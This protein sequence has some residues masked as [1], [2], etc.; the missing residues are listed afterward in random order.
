MVALRRVLPRYAC[1]PG[2]SGP[3]YAS[4][5]VRRT[6]TSPW[7][8]TAPSRRG[9]TSRTG[10]ARSSR[11]SAQ[12]VT[13]SGDGGGQLG[14]LLAHPLRGGATP[15]VARRHRALGG[16][17]LAHLRRQVRRDLR[18]L[19][20]AQ[21]V[22]LDPELL[23]PADA[24]PGDLVGHPEGHALAHQPLGDVGDRK[25]TRLNSSHSQISYA[26]FCL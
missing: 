1:E 12:P 16:E 25:S 4:T 26:V 19:L 2:S 3:S 24:G 9:A 15:A 21:L 10:P 6:A 14:Q 8:S 20:V 18:E 13:V 23:A 11:R 7:R 22:E 17:D 5:S